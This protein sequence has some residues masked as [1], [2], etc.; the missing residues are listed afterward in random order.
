MSFGERSMPGGV[1]NGGLVVRAGDTVRRP[2]GP[3]TPAV[4]ALLRH[5]ERVGFE[6]APRHL[7]Y[8]ERGREVLTY[9]PGEVAAYEEPPAW[10]ATDEALVSVTRLMRALHDATLGFVPPEGAKWAWPPPPH[11][12]GEVIGHNDACRENVV[13]D[14]TT[15]VALVDF[16]FA[17]PATRAWDVAGIV[18]HF[19]L[20][21]PGD[22][23][24]RYDLVLETY[25]VDDL[26]G[27]LLDRLE[28][29][30]AMVTERAARGEAGFVRQ[31]ESGIAERNAERRA[32]VQRL[33]G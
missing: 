32:L 31:V 8:D 6:G 16:D 12:R 10:V 7:G 26:K 11:R 20:G 25:P 29:G 27:A 24:R 23:Q 2:V 33:H 21:L 3:Q 22:V 15:A 30:L 4:A 5:L 17:G 13:F 1:G 14:G 9:V 28:W 18:R 19:V